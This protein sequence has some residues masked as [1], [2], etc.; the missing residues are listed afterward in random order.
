MSV[1]FVPKAVLWAFMFF[2]YIRVA[3]PTV[4]T[5]EMHLA[6]VNLNKYLMPD[7]LFCFLEDS[8]REE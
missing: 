6:R 4:K 7:L 8:M 1:S 3:R 2:T 5:Q